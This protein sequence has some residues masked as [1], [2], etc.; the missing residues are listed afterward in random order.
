MI[1]RYSI[2]GVLRDLNSRKIKAL[3]PNDLAEGSFGNNLEA[4]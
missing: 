3:S 4:G 1:S 2:I